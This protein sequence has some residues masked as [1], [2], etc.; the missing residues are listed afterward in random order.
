MR[1]GTSLAE[2]LLLAGAV[3]GLYKLLTPLQRFLETAI[4]DLLVGRG[5]LID[6]E[7]VSPKKKSSRN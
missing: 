7:T 3:Y 2:L 5:R 6:A 1:V 4:L